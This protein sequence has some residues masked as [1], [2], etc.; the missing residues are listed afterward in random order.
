M[1][2]E[3]EEACWSSSIQDL[4]I[5]TD[6]NDTSDQTELNC[7]DEEYKFDPFYEESHD[8]DQGTTSVVDDTLEDSVEVK[9][10]LS[11]PLS[12]DGNDIDD[13][14][15]FQNQPVILGDEGYEAELGKEFDVK[16]AVPES[17]SEEEHEPSTS[18]K[19]RKVAKGKVPK[20][21]EPIHVRSR[22]AK[23]VPCSEPSCSVMFADKSLAKIHF[24]EVHLGITRKVQCHFCQLVL[25]R[26]SYLFKHWRNRRCKKL[27]KC[28]VKQLIQLY[29]IQAQIVQQK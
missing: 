15:T 29:S 5:V 1:R 27:P 22:R 8:A 9:Q 14:P 20:T 7:L 13:N 23:T 6:V 19:R 2:N 25:S 17:S 24:S 11:E 28:D 4:N 18:S 21:K 12:Y 26:R 10:E 16:S 3:D